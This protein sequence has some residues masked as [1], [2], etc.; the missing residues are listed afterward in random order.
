MRLAFYAMIVA[1]LILT[2]CNKRQTLEPTEQIQLTQLPVSLAQLSNDA[3]LTLLLIDDHLLQ[4]WDNQSQQLIKQIEGS[5]YQ[6]TFRDALI[7]PSKRS[8][9][10]IS[11]TQLNIWQLHSNE[12][13]SYP[14]PDLTHSF[15][16]PRL[17]GPMT[18]SLSPLATMTAAYYF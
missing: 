12:V 13:V 14:L 17:C 4:V 7:A 16:L 1:L 8:M 3:A 6:L 10:S 15:A 11:D 2:G 9:L 5:K 18:S